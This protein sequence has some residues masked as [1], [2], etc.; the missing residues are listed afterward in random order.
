MQLLLAPGYVPLCANQMLLAISRK[1]FLGFLWFWIPFTT[2]FLTIFATALWQ[3]RRTEQF[4]AQ[5]SMTEH[6]E[7]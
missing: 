2:L 6:P 7:V 5:T 1:G 4:L 3:F